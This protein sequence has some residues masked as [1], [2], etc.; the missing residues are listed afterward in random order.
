MAMMSDLA[1]GGAGG[2]IPGFHPN[3]SPSPRGPGGAPV[4]VGG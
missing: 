3:M 1:R 2:E 4:G